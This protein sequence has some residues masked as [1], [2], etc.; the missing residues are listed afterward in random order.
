MEICH[1]WELRDLDQQSPN[2]ISAAQS[3]T[4]SKSFHRGSQR[5]VPL[6]KG[7]ICNKKTKKY[8]YIDSPQLLNLF[9]CHCNSLS[10][11]VMSLWAQEL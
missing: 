6:Y 7:K 4:G 9:A 2:S 10:E 8:D 1:P 11:G 5:E 3:N